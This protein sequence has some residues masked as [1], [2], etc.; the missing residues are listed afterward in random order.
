MAASFA[1]PSLFDTSALKSLAGARIAIVST[2]W[3]EAIVAK[4]IEGC[5]QVLEKFGAVVTHDLTVPGAVEIPFACRAVAAAEPAPEAVI[6]FGAVIRGGTPHFE[7]VCQSVTQG[8][9]TLNVTL[10]IPAIFGVLTL[11]N[12]AQAWERLGGVHGH[13]GEEAA[14]AA[15]KMI[16]L[17][18]ALTA[19]P[20]P[21]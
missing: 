16:A 5:R 11:D 6:A 1:S 4:L 15:L 8:L 21:D 12:E 18:R 13:K 3:N 9:T 19:W 7:Y 14:L 17:K 20:V 10:P 2:E